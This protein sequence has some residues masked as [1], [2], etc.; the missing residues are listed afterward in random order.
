MRTDLSKGL[1]AALAEVRT[2]PLFVVQLEVRPIILVGGPADAYRRVGVVFGGA[3]QGDRLSG[4]VLE[5]GN[6]WQTV[7]ADGTTKLDVRLPLKTEDGALICMTYGGLRSGPSDVIARF[8]RGEQVDPADYYYR[9]NPVF[10][11]ADRRYDWLNRIL[12]VGIGHRTA[13][14]PFYSVFE[15]L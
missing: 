9:I 7:G 10:E 2:R 12:A 8:D 4:E 13:G 11:T 6:D 1:P 5:G 3:F 14:G 15:I